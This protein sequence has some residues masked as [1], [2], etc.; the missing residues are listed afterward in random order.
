[1]FYLAPTA[2]LIL[3]SQGRVTESNTTAANM[4]GV[5]WPTL[6]ASSLGHFVAPESRSM[7]E[8]HFRAARR[9]VCKQVVELD[10]TR[11]DG[12]MVRVRLESICAFDKQGNPVGFRVAMVNLSPIPGL[13]GSAR[14]KLG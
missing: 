7:F 11:P 8:D 14:H 2:Y 3:D 4:L 9:E 12:A 5:N 1:M 10:L 6:L 13:A